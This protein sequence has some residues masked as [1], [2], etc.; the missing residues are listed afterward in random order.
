MP[1]EADVDPKTYEQYLLYRKTFF[2]VKPKR[3]S[4]RGCS[5]FWPA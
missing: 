5:A 1:N 3:L 4:R 2:A